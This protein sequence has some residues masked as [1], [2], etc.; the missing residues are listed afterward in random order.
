MVRPRP[1]F[2]E[3]VSYSADADRTSSKLT[4]LICRE[5][6]SKSDLQNHRHR[7]H[8]IK[9]IETACNSSKPDR[10]SSKLTSLISGKGRRA[11]LRPTD[12][13]HCIFSRRESTAK[14]EE[15]EGQAGGGGPPSLRAVTTSA[16]GQ[17][18]SDSSPPLRNWRKT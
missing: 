1:N 6:R 9:I 4:A 14:E 11:P 15:A 2:V 12:W 10:T 17:P 18:N 3:N 7:L 16:H 8:L 5:G 13:G